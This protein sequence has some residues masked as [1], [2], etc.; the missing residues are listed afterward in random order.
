V[1][2]TNANCLLAKYFLEESKETE[3]NRPLMTNWAFRTC[4]TY[5]VMLFVE[6]VCCEVGDIGGE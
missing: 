1:S 3:I 4:V 6:M 5:R 2:V